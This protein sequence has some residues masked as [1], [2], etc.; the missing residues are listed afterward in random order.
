MDKKKGG[1]IRR[2]IIIG[3]TFKERKLNLLLKTT[4]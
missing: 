4:P 1:W 3:K 2:I